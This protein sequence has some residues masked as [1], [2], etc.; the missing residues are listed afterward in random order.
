MHSVLAQKQ[1]KKK[2]NY[3]AE[4][5]TNG[6]RE[7]ETFKKLIGNVV[8]EQEGTTI[9]ADSAYFFDQRNLAEAYSHVRI[10]HE[11]SSVITSDTLI[12][13]GDNKLSQL[14][15]NVVYTSDSANL[16][17]D[18]LDYDASTKVAHFFDGGTLVQGNNT[19]TSRLGYYNERE[20][21]AT[22]YHKVE[23][24]NPE[25]ILRCDTMTYNTVTKIA[26]FKGPTKIISEDGSVLTTNEGGKYNATTQKSTFA[27]S[28]IETSSYTLTAERIDSDK[29]SSFDSATG[30]VVLIGK[31]NDVTILGDHGL[32]WKESGTIKIYDNALMKK[33]FEDDT[34]HLS[35]DT[36]LVR[37]DTQGVDNTNDILLA[38]NHVKLFMDNLQGKADSMAYHVIDSTIHFYNDP[39]L[40]HSASQITADSVDVIL[41]NEDI[42]QMHM[43]Q[44]AFIIQEDTLKNHNQLKGRKMVAYFK[45][46]EIDHLTVDG[47][48]ESIYFVIDDNLKLV[49]MNHIKCS[50]MHIQMEDDSVATI[51]VYVKPTGVFQPPH[52]I[53]E[54]NK[55]LENFRWRI[56]ERPTKKEVLGI[57]YDKKTSYEEFTF[58]K[59]NKIL[60]P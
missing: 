31:E 50:N 42:D 27:R 24:I 9:Y 30:N 37:E 46:N 1:D 59:L 3:R 39:V 6:S 10:I 16:Y 60:P 52:R 5:L 36:L 38:Y 20:K 11:D 53:T 49:G 58:N 26:T 22:F 19:L 48:S 43:N 18:N 35:A 17:T 41:K 25:Y 40:W 56:L 34:L 51:T 2:L 21:I 54:E 57:H 44:N 14:R 12:Y 15:N 47:N 23:L 29:S 45:E 4:T 8:F 7:G 13:D 33:V 28:K 32:Y 55:K